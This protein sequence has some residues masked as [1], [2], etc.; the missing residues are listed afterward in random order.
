MKPGCS[1]CSTAAVLLCVTVLGVAIGCGEEESQTTPAE[2]SLPSE[3]TVVRPLATYSLGMRLQRLGGMS[4]RADRMNAPPPPAADGDDVLAAHERTVEF[5]LRDQYDAEVI[6]R[7]SY[8]ARP[9][10][11]MG[12]WHRTKIVASFN[13]QRLPMAI[14][15]LQDPP[16]HR[17]LTYLTTVY[18][19]PSYL[20]TGDFVEPDFERAERAIFEP[21]LGPF[22]LEQPASAEAMAAIELLGDRDL[23]VERTGIDNN[24]SGG[25]PDRKSARNIFSYRMKSPAALRAM[26]LLRDGGQQHIELLLS[27]LDDPRRT[28]V[29]HVLLAEITGE[30][31]ILRLEDKSADDASSL[32]GLPIRVLAQS[33]TDVAE[34]HRHRVRL[35]WR[36]WWRRAQLSDAPSAAS[37]ASKNETPR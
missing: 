34:R 16:N 19:E 1:P 6:R 2:A 7:D 8:P 14:Y 29:A 20:P 30:T 26:D 15:T 11:S 17:G 3:A 24:Q 13:N 4:A 37:A 5:Y 35:A 31:N 25:E 21:P 18:I 12:P 27:A 33:K 23:R 10:V 32:L 36:D 28:V 22:V 9:P